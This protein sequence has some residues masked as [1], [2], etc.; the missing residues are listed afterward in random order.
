MT[1]Q[2]EVKVRKVDIR[3]MRKLIPDTFPVVKELFEV[4]AKCNEDDRFCYEATFPFGTEILDKGESCLLKE[5][6]YPVVWEDAVSGKQP[7]QVRKEFKDS[8]GKNTDHPLSIILQGEVEIYSWRNVKLSADGK[9]TGKRHFPLND[10]MKGDWF[11]VYGTNDLIAQHEGVDV[12]RWA[13]EREWAAIAGSRCLTVGVPLPLVGKSLPKYRKSFIKVFDSLTEEFKQTILNHND[14]ERPDIIAGFEEALYKAFCHMVNAVDEDRAS[15]RVLI[16]PE[17]YFI[18]KKGEKNPLRDAKL[19]LQRRIVIY[20]WGQS[21]SERDALWKQRGVVKGLTEI[22]EPG[23]AIARTHLVELALGKGYCMRTVRES[24][25]VVHR[26]WQILCER[27]DQE[28]LWAE[29][30]PLLLTYSRGLPADGLPAVVFSQFMP[31]NMATTYDGWFVKLTEAQRAALREA[32]AKHYPASMKR[33]PEVHFVGSSHDLLRRFLNHEKKVR[34]S[35]PYAPLFKH[36]P[37]LGSKLFST[38]GVKTGSKTKF[39]PAYFDN[40]FL[41]WTEAD[42]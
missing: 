18:P 35:A 26:G 37:D 42:V 25:G 23:V 11:G 20:G 17:H 36:Q 29:G 3:K 10:L 21:G 30:I 32:V 9:L 15:T 38:N 2:T 14:Q 4:V 7:A 5:D 16:I 34:A 27:W 6:T 33:K 1:H 13:G 39:L 8:C 24:D 12:D 31:I 41:L 28:K 40:A 19:K 22:Q